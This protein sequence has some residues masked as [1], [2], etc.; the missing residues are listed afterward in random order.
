MAREKAK[1]KAVMAMEKEEMKDSIDHFTKQQQK[2]SFNKEEDE[3]ESDVSEEGM[4][5]LEDESEEEEDETSDD[6]V[7]LTP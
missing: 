6:E 5:N 3:V 7:T 2:I 1:R 4:F